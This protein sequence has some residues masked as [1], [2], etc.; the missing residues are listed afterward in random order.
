MLNHEKSWW[1]KGDFL[2][3]NIHIYQVYFATAKEE[4]VPKR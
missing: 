1:N 4:K 3:E 2:E